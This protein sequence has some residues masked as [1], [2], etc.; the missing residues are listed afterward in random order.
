M[1]EERLFGAQFAALREAGHRC[2]GGDLTS[3]DSIGALA[4]E[5]L[6]HAPK[7]FVAVGLSM[8]GI[9]A[10]EIIRQAPERVSH[11]A[12]LNTTYRSDRIAVQ[13]IEQIERVQSGELDLVL[14]DELKPRYMSPSNRT[15]DRL[16]L[17]SE[18]A[19]DLGETVFAR[20]SHALMN[21]RSYREL[22]SEIAC[23]TL[24]LTGAN[25]AICPPELHREMAEEI[26]DASLE[27]VEDCGHL[28]PL[29]RPK[30]VTTALIK[31]VA[32]A[33]SPSHR[34]DRF[35]VGA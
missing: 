6:E 28:S 10:L 5:I 15:P 2:A 22:L 25:D 26:P 24:V 1:C 8:G 35:A 33:S 23:P 18:M 19:R 27:I 14:R 32:P 4:S 29:E 11:L 34:C 31:L 21:R 3:C 20:Q 12:L 30:A 9:V 13:R 7:R 16:E 17:L